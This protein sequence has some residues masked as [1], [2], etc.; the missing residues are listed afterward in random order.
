MHRTASRPKDHPP[1]FRQIGRS[2]SKRSLSRLSMLPALLMLLPSLVWAAPA[3]SHGTGKAPNAA[4]QRV[5]LVTGSTGGLGR[6][7]A[8]ALAAQGVH[9]LVHG[10]NQ[11]A[12]EA[13][14]RELNEGPGR[15]T[16]H[17]ADLGSLAETRRLAE[18]I[19]AGYSR[20]D[21][22]VANAGIW[23]GAEDGR[24]VSVDGHELH[25]QV[26]YLSHFLLTRLLLPRLRE[27][28]AAHGEARIVQVASTAQSPID[29]DDVMLERPGAANRGYGQSKLAQILFTVDLAEE[30]AGTGVLPVSVHPATLMDTGMVRERGIAPRATVEEGVEAV[31]ALLT[32]ADLEPG[33][34]YRGLE[35]AT[36]NAQALDPEARRRL[37]TLS[38]ALTGLPRGADT[39]PTR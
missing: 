27:T 33:A 7:V 29:F 3:K 14:V 32:R 39:P 23:L 17:A 8:R 38:L 12:G 22:V 2:L 21:A 26:N 10:R 16:F 18:E 24:Q 25:F 11:E 19:L 4:N 6:D 20:L 15:A 9:V 36:P 28:A 37:R 35:R 34:Y 1:T 31:M 5:I 30:L 13:L